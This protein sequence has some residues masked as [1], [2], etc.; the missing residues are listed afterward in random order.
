MGYGGSIGYK[1]RSLRQILVPQNL[2]YKGL[3]MGYVY[4]A[5][6]DP[7]VCT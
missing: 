5:L 4:E 6:R 3:I 7:T 2:G 1:T